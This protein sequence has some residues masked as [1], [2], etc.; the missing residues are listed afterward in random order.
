MRAIILFGLL[1]TGLSSSAA[2]IELNLFYYSDSFSISDTENSNNRTFWD[3]CPTVDL[4]S[5][6]RFN[7]GWNYASMSFTDKMDTAETTLTIVDMGPKFTYYFDKGLHWPLAFTYNLI[8]TGKY[9]QGSSPSAE[10]RG[11][12]MKVEVGYTPEVTEKVFIGAKLNYYKADFKEE[13]TGDT[14]LAKV[15]NGRSTIYPSFSFLY[16]WN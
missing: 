4:T 5:K 9:T 13:V 11:T 3:I 15:T 1:W 8:S 6:G 2:T 10:Q 16:R 7:V 12:S 14:N